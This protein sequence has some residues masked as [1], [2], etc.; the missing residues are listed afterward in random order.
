MLWD[1]DARKLAIDNMMR[2][3]QPKAKEFFDK[4]KGQL[5]G[6]N[7]SKGP[8]KIATC[9]TK[10]GWFGVGEAPNF[11]TLDVEKELRGLT[12]ALANVA[13]NG[14]VAA[15]REKV[16]GVDVVSFSLDD[17]KG[18]CDCLHRE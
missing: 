8:R 3:S 17:K 4:L 12:D 16:A 11:A 6:A 10:D 9:F 7:L 5:D 13:A 1:A 15:K 18:W 14:L 2:T